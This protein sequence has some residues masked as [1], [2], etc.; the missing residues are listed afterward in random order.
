MRG[1]EEEAEVGSLVK[2][3]KTAGLGTSVGARLRRGVFE[4]LSDLGSLPTDI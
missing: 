1:Q 4:N 2:E 3:E